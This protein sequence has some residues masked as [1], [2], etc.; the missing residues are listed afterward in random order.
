[1]V[2][3]ALMLKRWFVQND[4]VPSQVISDAPFWTIHRLNMRAPTTMGIG[5][6]ESPCTGLSSILSQAGTSAHRSGL[7]VNILPHR[8]E[9][10][11]ERVILKGSPGERSVVVTRHAHNTHTCGESSGN[12]HRR[13]SA[14]YMYYVYVKLCHAVVLHAHLRVAFEL[15]SS[16]FKKKGFLS[17]QRGNTIEGENTHTHT[18][19]HTMHVEKHAC[20]LLN[21]N[22]GYY[23][24][25]V[26][27][28]PHQ[29][30]RLRLLYSYELGTAQSA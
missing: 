21:I 6:N 11:A 5:R 14:I 15:S 9:E 4:T 29:Q 18:H 12:T 13:H 3:G 17:S 24:S 23:L 30:R 25:C 28:S 20:T 2:V 26:A 27:H 10:G 8:R 16:P 19:T 7:Q 22:I 1:M